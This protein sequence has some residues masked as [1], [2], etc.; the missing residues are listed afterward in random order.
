RRYGGSGLGL[1]ICSR[2]VQ[3][4]GGKLEVESTPGRGSV[5][6]FSI[7]LPSADEQLPL[8]ETSLPIETALGLEVL[9][10]EDNDV[11]RRILA[12]QLTRLGCRFTMVTNGEEALA[13]LDS[14][15]PPDVILMDCHM[16]KLD[17][18]ATTERLRRWSADP[19]PARRAAAA[20]PIVALT[21]A[22]L[23][24][25]RTR[26]LAAGMNDFIAKPVKLAELQASL[27]RFTRGSRVA[28]EPPARAA[29][30]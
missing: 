20:L 24:E 17:G 5:F 13:A 8:P 18:W 23:P 27:A 3:M 9:V 11:N 21:A 4:M 7:P 29:T 2:L 19:L 12:S 6:Y 1:A 30:E 25:E 28:S 14:D 15:A 22:A 26:C 10:A 16:P